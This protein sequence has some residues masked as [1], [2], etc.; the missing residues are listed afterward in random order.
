MAALSDKLQ[1]A[2][3]QYEEIA[4]QHAERLEAFTKVARVGA[5]NAQQLGA[6]WLHSHEVLKTVYD[7]VRVA[8]RPP[9]PSGTKVEKGS[10]GYWYA[11]VRENGDWKEIS[12]GG[13][14]HD[15]ITAVLGTARG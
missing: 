6:D 11:F 13:S 12:R 3:D 5:P 4:K 8:Q 2:L 9:L 7:A 1:H 14:E 10:D 15:A